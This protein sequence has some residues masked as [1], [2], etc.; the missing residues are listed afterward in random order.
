MH[1]IVLLNCP[2]IGMHIAFM[3]ACAEAC[4]AFK[5]M[6]YT[7]R[8]ARS[9]SELSDN[10]IVFLGNDIHAPNPAIMLARQA[11][12]AVYIGWYW[13]EQDVRQLPHFMH[14]C[15]YKLK[16]KESLTY[17]GSGS[18][19]NSIVKVPFL[20]RANDDPALIGTYAKDIARHYCY[21]GYRYN[22]EMV[23]SSPK[24]TGYYYGTK[25]LTRFLNYETRKRI[26][27][28]SMFALGFQSKSNADEQH[29]SQRIYEGLAYGCIVLSNSEAARDQT[30]GI[31]EFVS[32]RREIE[33]KMD[34][35]LK[36]PEAYV[37]KQ[38]AG[39]HFIKTRGGT[40]HATAQLFIDAANTAFPG[41]L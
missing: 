19:S 20:L 28:S 39:Y 23:P 30:D 35:Y 37:A 22:P 2:E 26:Y 6:G 16:P 27:L 15:E 34:Y 24:Y 29:V 32:S 13:N 33:A 4:H 9:I 36:N 5:R 31:V 18:S 10:C 14:T 7:V 25:N 21:M 41:I 11:P 8:I 12:R 17:F 40:N 3:Y 38:T 1:E